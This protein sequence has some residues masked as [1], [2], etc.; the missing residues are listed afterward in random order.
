MKDIYKIILFLIIML[1]VIFCCAHYQITSYLSLSAFNHYQAK[2]LAF[3]QNNLY[4]FTLIYICSYILLIILCIPGTIFFDLVAGFVFGPLLGMLW[5][6]I[7]Y[8]IGAIINFLVVRF[9]LK[10]IFY[11]RFIYLRHKLLNGNSKHAI[12]LNLIGLRLIPVIP[13]GV[14]NIGA[15]IL[16]IPFKLFTLTTF[17]GIIP[18]AMI[19]VMLGY[20]VHAQLRHSQEINSSIL[21]D[22]SL[23]IPLC[24]VA[25]LMLLPSIF[26]KKQQKLM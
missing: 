12:M 18:P 10:D 13:F 22:S 26:K 9:L 4:Q 17:L 25:I 11:Q 15:A 5:V 6:V 8:L 7:S 2:I 21:F 14:L 24:A 3:H 23:M 16:D 1:G 20:E 19:Y